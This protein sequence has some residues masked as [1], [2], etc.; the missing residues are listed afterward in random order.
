MHNA[1]V[2]EMINSCWK[3]TLLVAQKQLPLVFYD[4]MTC[5]PE[6]FAFQSKSAPIFD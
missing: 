2:S 5:F 1:A 3:D 4:I 6:Y